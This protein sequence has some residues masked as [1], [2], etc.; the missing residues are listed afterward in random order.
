MSPFAHTVRATP[1]VRAIRLL[2]LLSVMIQD[3][4]IHRYSGER[5]A[6]EDETSDLEDAE[7]FASAAASQALAVRRGKGKGRLSGRGKGKGRGK[8]GGIRRGGRGRRGCAAAIQGAG[9]GD[10]SEEDEL[11]QTAETAEV[12][13]RQAVHASL[14]GRSQAPSRVDSPSRLSDSSNHGGGHHSSYHGHDH[15]D[16]DGAGAGA[17]NTFVPQS[18]YDNL[19]TYELDDEDDDGPGQLW[20]QQ[21]AAT[22]LK[23]LRCAVCLG[24][25]DRAVTAPCMHRFCQV[26]ALQRD[27]ELPRVSALIKPLIKSALMKSALIKPLIYNETASSQAADT[28]VHRPS[29]HLITLSLALALQTRL[30]E[31]HT[32]IFF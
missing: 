5:E 8:S 25:I 14:G 29:A 6:D 11:Q 18:A 20:L 21:E 2:P 7:P 12:E 24:I 23:T 1:C 28:R 17:R 22:L 10:G 19:A 27:S 4:L 32:C 9:V 13:L 30:A 16:G 31:C 26:T 3:P 15:G